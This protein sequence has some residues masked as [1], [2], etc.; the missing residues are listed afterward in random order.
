MLWS[1]DPN[2]KPEMALALTEFE[3]LCGFRPLPEIAQNLN[4][5]PELASLI[6]PSILSHFHEVA[7]LPSPD[8]PV[9]KAALRD[10]FAAVMTTPPEEVHKAVESLISRYTSSPSLPTQNERTLQALLPRLHSQFPYDIGLLCPFL[11]NILHLN[12]GSA[13]FLGAGEPHAYLSGEAIECMANSDN[14]IRAGL[15][16]KLRDVENLVA[17]LTYECGEGT[18]HGVVATSFGE[19]G[20]GGRTLLYDPPIEEFSVLKTSVAPGVRAS[21]RAI[22]GPSLS[23]VT[24]GRGMLMWAEGQL[25]VGMGDVLFVGAGVGV[26]FAVGE[27]ALGG[28]ELVVY[29]AFVEA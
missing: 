22:A 1:I 14:V 26:E 12:P 2:H 8:P 29:Q 23:I 24:Q 18:R 28:E 16:P 7:A 3:A 4:V 25:E 13:I 11:L 6:P 10:L 20:Q 5:T 21:H 9:R 15:T 17:G 27:N 19:D